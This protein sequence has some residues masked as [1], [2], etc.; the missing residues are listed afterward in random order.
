MTRGSVFTAECIIPCLTF[1][2]ATTGAIVGGIIGSNTSVSWSIGGS[3]LG[4][5]GSLL[6]GC[7]SYTCY[8]CGMYMLTMKSDG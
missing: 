7:I 8:E 6:L 3:F 5:F 4:F 2:S 1:A